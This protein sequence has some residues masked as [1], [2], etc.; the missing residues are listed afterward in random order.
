[1]PGLSPSLTSFMPGSAGDE[2]LT[3]FART[4]TMCTQVQFTTS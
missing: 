1:M 3:T 4:Y 2:D